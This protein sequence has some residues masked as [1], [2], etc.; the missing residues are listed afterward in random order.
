[1]MR[2]NDG[3]VEIGQGVSNI[4]NFAAVTTYKHNPG[5]NWRWQASAGL[6][7]DRLDTETPFG[8]SSTQT[9]RTQASVQ[10]ERGIGGYSLW[11]LGMDSWHEAGD[12]S[13]NWAGDSYDSGAWPG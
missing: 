1:M 3:D 6:L 8:E 4:Q 2:G 13:D 11:L 12:S 9:R 10:A 7:R 5:E